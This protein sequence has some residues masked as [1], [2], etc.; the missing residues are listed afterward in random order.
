MTY[1][2]Q[3]LLTDSAA[4]S[5]RRPAVAVGE[6]SLSYAELDALSNQ[7]ARTLL[8]QGVAAGDRVGILA[9]KSAASV[10]ALFGVLKAGAC[11]VPL[12]PKS[13]APR[14]AAIMSDSGIGVVLAD[15]ASSQQAAALAGRVPVLRTVI[16]AGPHWGREA[17]PPGANVTGPDVVDWDA[18]L[19]APDLTLPDGRAIETDLAYILYTSGST[20]T[21]KGVMISHR[22]SLTFVNWAVGC[23]GLSDQDRV[24]SPAPLNFDLSVFDVFA[25]CQAAACLV[26]VPEMTARFPSRLAQWL[27]QER[28]SVWYSVP[29][30]LTML[31][32]YGNLGGFDLSALR[33]VIFAGE[34][35]PAKHLNALLAQLPGPR[36]LNWY[37]PTETN[38][39][40][41]FEVPRGAA[42]LTA[43]V[44]IGRGC[45]NTDVFAVTSDGRLV[46]RPG[47]EGELYARGPGLMRGYWGDQEKTERALVPAPFRPAFGE[48]A[49]R[50]GD[51]VTLDDEDNFRYLGRRDGMVKTRGYRVELGEV[52]TA[53]YAHPA[54]RE[55][56]VL[57]VPDELLGSRLR[58][59]IAVGGP[60]GLTREEVLGHCRRRLPGYMVPDIVEFCE[61][62]PRNSN[63]KV[64][65][66]RL[67]GPAPAVQR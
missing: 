67:A 7:V 44:P 5:P 28:I 17:A 11:Y 25:S 2:L 15:Q 39:C 4:R 18:V 58:A 27:E 24:C 3:Q 34:V 29:S 56:V 40:T 6:R 36:Y 49:Y 50:T 8:A 9:P 30:V 64:D 42:G 13:P 63:G 26:V 54:V 21:P 12:D 1:L 47:E 32:S 66:A 55:A 22:A 14:L 53:L 57:P 16:V 41:W 59:V 45:A 37:G 46:S 20:G 33:A 52:E 43:P 35:F 19:A 62:L 51:L 48:L 65:R 60:G 38:V 61:K 31:A 23:T 10:V